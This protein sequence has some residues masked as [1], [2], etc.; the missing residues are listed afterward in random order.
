M[1]AMKRDGGILRTIQRHW[2]VFSLVAVIHCVLTFVFTLWSMGWQMILLDSGGR[3]APA[4][5]KIVSTIDLLLS[6]PVLFP[7]ARL[8]L[9]LGF[10]D[11]A[12]DPIY[13]PLPI[14]NSLLVAYAVTATVRWYGARRQAFAQRSSS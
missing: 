11:R 10:P 1:A 3:V 9:Y 6:L 12:N 7:L 2:I 5:L 14:V 8:A 13:W 4:G